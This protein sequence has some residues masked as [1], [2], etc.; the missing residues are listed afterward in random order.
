MSHYKTTFAQ[1]L[2]L[3]LL[4]FL[5][6]A[7]PHESNSSILHDAACDYGLPCTRDQVETELAWLAEQGLVRVEK[8]IPTLSVVTLLRRGLDVAQGRAVVPGV[9]T[10]TPEE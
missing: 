9:K 2:R 1:H 7:N 5:A 8:P 6:E 10:R 3:C 4:R